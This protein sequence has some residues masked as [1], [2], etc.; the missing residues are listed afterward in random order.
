MARYPEGQAVQLVKVVPQ[1]G[2]QLYELMPPLGHA[3][4]VAEQPALAACCPKPQR[5]HETP[6]GAQVHSLHER[7]QWHVSSHA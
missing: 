2:A 5:P 6:V 3:P 4:H 1:F 7:D